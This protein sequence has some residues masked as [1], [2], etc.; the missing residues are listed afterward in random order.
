MKEKYRILRS[1]RLTAYNMGIR[2]PDEAQII[3]RFLDEWKKR[4]ELKTQ[5]EEE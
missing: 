5:K 3:S 2:F 1:M 4:Q